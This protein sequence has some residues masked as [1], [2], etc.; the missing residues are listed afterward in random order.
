MRK[1]FGLHDRHSPFR[2]NPAT[3]FTGGVPGLVYDLSDISTLFQDAAGTTPVTAI[4]DPV[5]RILDKSGNGNHATQSSAGARPLLQQTNGLYHLTFDGSDDSMATGNIDLTTTSKMEV[6][7]GLRKL[8]D[9]AS[10]VVVGHGADFA[11]VGAWEFQANTSAN[12]T[13][14]LRGRSSSGSTA[15]AGF[16]RN[17][18]APAT[19]VLAA[20]VNYDAAAGAEFSG[21]YNGSV[22]TQNVGPTQQNTGTFGNNPL[23]IGSRQGGASQFFNGHLYGLIVFGAQATDWQIWAAEQWMAQRTGISF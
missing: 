16:T 21:R 5:G 12:A 23:T 4:G 10:S 15:Q 2:L 8:S 22:Q 3:F 11:T 17:V 18:V 1:G 9:A 14:A 19:F 13:T 20:S 6:F 7:A